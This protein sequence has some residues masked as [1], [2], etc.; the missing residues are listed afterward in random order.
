M[1]PIT[2]IQTKAVLYEDSK[3]HSTLCNSSPPRR[4]HCCFFLIYSAARPPGPAVAG[5]G[6][7]AQHA[8]H[9]QRPGVEGTE[10]HGVR[11]VP[12]GAAQLTD[13]PPEVRAGHLP[14]LPQLVTPPH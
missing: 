3:T 9:G 11:G 4:P 13:L 7:V 12:G 14:S 6:G 5:P 2:L 10:G 1:K 8:G